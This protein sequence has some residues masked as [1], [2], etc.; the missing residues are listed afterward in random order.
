VKPAALITGCTTGI[1][2]ACALELAA[3][4]H[5]VV[6]TAR[7]VDDL[8][9]LDV[10]LCLQLDVT[11]D[12]S[13]EAAIER[14]GDIGLLVNNAGISAWGP[15]ELLGP[16][17]LQRVLATNVV[18]VAR[19]TSAVLPGMRARR[20]GTIVNVSTAALRGFPLL[21]AYAASKAAL[22]AWTEALRLEVAS[23]G[24]TV[25]LVE[26]AGV[27][28]AFAAN[29]LTVEIDDDYRAL[30]RRA[31]DALTRMRGGAMRSEEVA[32]AIAD[33]MHDDDAPLRNPVGAD[34]RRILEERRTLDDAA[35]EA[36][37]RGIVATD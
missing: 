19:V 17:L 10:D 15:V 25:T 22:E 30:H 24:I 32:V 3:R 1:G 5:R 20:A 34:A 4:G 6:A 2:R 21:G 11:D 29:R 26:P 31:I 7:R 9:G 8:A 36:M 37:V 14:A 13:V 16:D 28:S 12:G 18:G 33:V 23:F 27:E 35:Y